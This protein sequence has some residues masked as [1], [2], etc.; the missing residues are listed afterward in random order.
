[1]CP[2]VAARC[3]V[4]Y[5][6]RM[7]CVFFIIFEK[8]FTRKDHLVN[9]V[10]QHTGES[11]HKC[12]YCPKTFTRKEHLTNHTRKHTGKRWGN[13]KHFRDKKNDQNI[14]DHSSIHIF[15][16]IV[17][18]RSAALIKSIAV[19]SRPYA[20]VRYYQLCL[21]TVHCHPISKHFSKLFSIASLISFVAE[22]SLSKNSR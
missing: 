5:R 18:R 9:H 22:I 20:F 19:D 11:P 2:F 14:H 15:I 13:R 4:Y 1:M 3:H 16:D 7:K 21:R 6:K 10:R 17:I 12:T 8:A